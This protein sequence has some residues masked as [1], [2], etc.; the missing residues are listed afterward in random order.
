MNAFPAYFPLTGRKVV[1]VGTNDHAE[2]KA[3]LFVG[4]PAELTRIG[5]D[6]PEAFDPATYAGAALAFISTSSEADDIR[7]AQAARAAHVPVNVVDRPALCDF[8]TPALVDRGE[9]VV[10]IGTG[11]NAP[12]L[13][14]VLRKD[15]EAVVPQGAGRLAALLGGLRGEIREA[16]PEF[17]ARRVFLL[18][19]L[20][21][22]AAKAALDGDL[23]RAETLLRAAIAEK[24]A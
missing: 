8:F 21:G 1:I 18:A 9:V 14:A 10:A 2:G 15:I 6:G 19:V 23:D 3:K 5:A 7:A 24:R 22:P 13:S 12:L 20:D 17:E 11:G 4:S 16:F